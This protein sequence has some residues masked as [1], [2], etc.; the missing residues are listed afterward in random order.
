MQNQPRIAK[1]RLK[2]ETVK[3]KFFSD[4]ECVQDLAALL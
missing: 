3:W 4:D 1:I 2:A